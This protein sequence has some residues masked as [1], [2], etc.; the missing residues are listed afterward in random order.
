MNLYFNTGNT[1]FK[2][3]PTLEGIIWYKSGTSRLFYNPQVI[4]CSYNSSDSPEVTID[5]VQFGDGYEQVTEAGLNPVRNVFE[6][7]FTKIRRATGRAVS[8]FLQGEPE[9]SIYYRRPSEWFYWVP[10]YPLA[11]IDSQ[12]L[13]IRCEKWRI[14]AENFDTV[15]IDATF[16]K[17]FEP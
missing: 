5:K 6:V 4:P 9:G 2:F 15:N 12:P 10:P 8:R 7:R 14:T 13:K 16:V 1:V 11:A 3:D 17:T